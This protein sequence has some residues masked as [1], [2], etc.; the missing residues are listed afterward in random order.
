[1]Q[2]I[3]KNIYTWRWWS[4]EKQLFFNGY[5]IY[6][7]QGNMVIDPPQLT[8]EDLAHLKRLGGV[9]AV[10]ITNM[11]HK[12]QV[13]VLIKHFD[14]EVFV[15]ENDAAQLEIN[16]L[17]TFKD[18]DAILDLKVVTIPHNKTPGESALWYADQRILFVGD[19]LIG[20]PKGEVS[21]LPAEKFADINSA[22]L[23]ILRMLEYD[24]DHLL[25][26][27]GDPIVGN[28]KA[29]VQKFIKGE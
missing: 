1:M 9:D 5:C 29:V 13:D 25:M 6:N 26:G 12:R 4:E 23:G 14:P 2:E 22:K 19:A 16:E 8:D 11:H 17:Q 18:G 10:V 21:L 7:P 20:K 3:V 27:D 15:H 24:F 28:A